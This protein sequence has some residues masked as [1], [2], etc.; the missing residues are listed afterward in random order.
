M[1]REKAS[2]EEWGSLY[3]HATKLKE[4]E[5]WNDFWDVDLISI[6]LP[7]DEEPIFVS[8]LG[9]AGSCYG[10]SCY[11]GLSGLNDF[12]MMSQQE[13]LGLS[14]EDVMFIQ[15]N[16]TCYWGNRDEL[17]KEQYEI[18][19]ELGYKYRGNGNWL[20]FISY[21]TGYHPFNLN[22]EEVLNLTKYFEILI[23][24][25]KHYRENDIDVDFE[26]EEMFSYYFD[27]NTKEWHGKAMML[28]MTD[29]SFQSLKLADEDLIEELRNAK[30]TRGVLEVDLTYL[31]VRVDDEKFERPLNPQMYIIADYKND[32]IITAQVIE[33]DE[34]A[35]VALAGAIIGFILEYGAPKKI[36]IKNHLVASVIAD[37]CEKCNIEIVKRRSLATIDNFLNEF[38]RFQR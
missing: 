26:G 9:R 25:V 10:I 7:E 32:M 16:L 6:Q 12:I 28:P 1:K 35:P 34:E 5:P 8:V 4:L 23:E 30:K 3:E 37:I 29:Y 2:I 20:Y 13:N 24:A 27:H 14:I 21:K 38:K 18:I 17:S 33:G 22:K 36:I 19:K 11:Q 15:N 31:G